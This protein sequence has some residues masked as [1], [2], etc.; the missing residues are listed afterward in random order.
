VAISER[1][2]SRKLK[3]RDIMAYEQWIAIKIVSENMTLTVR[4]TKLDP[5]K[6]HTAA[7]KDEEIKPSQINGTTI[8][9][10]K[11]V[12][13]FSSGRKDSPTG[14]KGSIDL[15]HGDV[16]VGIFDWNCPWGSKRNSFNW[17]PDASKEIYY[18]SITGG[19]RSG[20]IGEVTIIAIKQ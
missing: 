5:G 18:T 7:S 3:F 9:S 8:K 6:F 11:N 13:I 16:R 4:N 19:R 15:Y 12:W 17:W 10:G 1:P 14:T 20:A 2:R